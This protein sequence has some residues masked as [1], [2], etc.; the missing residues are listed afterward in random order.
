MSRKLIT[1][2]VRLQQRNMKG[3]PG[4]Y[5]SKSYM[6]H[7]MQAR[8][9]SVLKTVQKLQNLASQI[10]IRITNPQFNNEACKACQDSRVKFNLWV[11][12]TTYF[13][14]V[15]IFKGKGNSMNTCVQKENKPQ[16]NQL[17]DNYSLLM[18]TSMILPG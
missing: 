9:D 1:I 12:S 16:N 4:I 13:Y 14:N 18:S 8:L 2:D 5:Q 6:T 11:S 10:S 7:N 17:A 15:E 3:R